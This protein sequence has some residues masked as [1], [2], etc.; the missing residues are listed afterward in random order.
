MSLYHLVRTLMDMRILRMTL[1]VCSLEYSFN[2]YPLEAHI[3]IAVGQYTL[4]ISAFDPRHLGQFSLE[5]SS[6]HRFDLEPIPQEGAGMFS[7][8]V[9]GFW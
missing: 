8:I 3:H 1:Q 6:S 9:K 7:K 4:I 2:R 5:F